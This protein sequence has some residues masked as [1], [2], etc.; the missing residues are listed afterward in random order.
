MRSGG[1]DGTTAREFNPYLLGSSL[2]HREAILSSRIEGTVT[3]PERL[4][5]PAAE[6]SRADRKVSEDEDRRS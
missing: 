1:L 5:L 2:L 4:V 3:T 6:S